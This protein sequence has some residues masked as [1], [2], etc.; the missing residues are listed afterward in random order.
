MKEDW[1]AVADAVNSRAAELALKQRELAEKSGVS[2]AIVREIQQGRIQRRRNPRT[3]E[4]LSIALDWHPQ[5]L[6]AVLTGQTPPDADPSAA[7]VDNP[8]IPLL[9]TII[10]EIR[11]L[12]AQLGTL[13]NRLDEGPRRKE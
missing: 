7:P 9:N 3:L 1:S 11:G 10:R 13:T 5:H 2:L 12:R 6:T 4:A 8:I